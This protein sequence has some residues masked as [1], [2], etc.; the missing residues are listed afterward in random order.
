MKRS[1]LFA[2]G[3]LLGGALLFTSCG[4]EEKTEDPDV[5]DAAVGNFNGTVTT[6]WLVD[7]AFEADEDTFGSPESINLTISKDGT[8]SN[9]IKIDVDGD[10]FY[11][12]KIEG[13][14][15]GFGFDIESQNYDGMNIK[16]YNAGKVGTTEYHGVYL[17]DEKKFI[18][19]F[20]V[21]I[22][23][24]I[25]KSTED[26]DDDDEKEAT[27]AILNAAFAAAGAEAVVMIFETNK[28]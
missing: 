26:I 11:G 8:N 1:L 18:A 21:S 7:G 9:A 25:K 3:A 24:I 22:K 16:G 12:S 5:R 17:D 6:Y 28:R 10:I 19:G 20:Q 23:D 27:A 15:N 4:K 14:S 13:A 2:M